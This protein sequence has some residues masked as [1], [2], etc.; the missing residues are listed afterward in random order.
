MPFRPPR[1]GPLVDARDGTATWRV[2][3]DEVVH[4]VDQAVGDLEPPRA[5]TG[6]AAERERGQRGGLWWVRVP[7]PA[8]WSLAVL[9][10]RGRATAAPPPLPATLLLASRIAE[11]LAVLPDALRP[12]VEPTRIRVDRLGEVHLVSPWLHARPLGPGAPRP[13]PEGLRHVLTWLTLLPLA[14]TRWLSMRRVLDLAGHPEPW[15]ETPGFPAS[16]AS[17]LQADPARRPVDLARELRRLAAIESDG[18]SGDPLARWMHD[19]R[20]R[21]VAEDAP[22]DTAVADGER[23]AARLRPADEPDDV[24]LPSAETTAPVIHDED[25]DEEDTDDEPTEPGGLARPRPSLSED[26]TLLADSA[27]D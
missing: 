20:L 3:T 12:G 23:L 8:S 17:F 6:F 7:V 4:A 22:S 26:E 2:G 25:A 16:V 19:L 11:R 5:L 1:L 13:S 24:D 10:E 18:S 9:A 27:D 21:G 14:A 15:E